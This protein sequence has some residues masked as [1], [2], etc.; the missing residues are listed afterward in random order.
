[1]GFA[2]VRADSRHKRA[3]NKLIRGTKIG[4]GF[5]G[6]VPRNTWIAKTG[7]RIVGFAELEFIG[8]KAA[9]LKGVAVDEEFRHQGIGSALIGHRFEVGRKQGVRV[10]A[11]CTMYYL[12]KFYKK[13]GFKTCPREFLPEF[14]RSYPQFAAKRYRKCAVMVKG[15]PIRRRK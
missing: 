10:F 12:F 14:L 3:I 5:K 7:G 9:I 11:L 1:M 6:P 13:Y 2:I 15:V 4:S 8:K